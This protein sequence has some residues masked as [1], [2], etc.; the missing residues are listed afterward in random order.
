MN[1]T[2]D[3][4]PTV[5][6]DAP[7]IVLL[8]RKGGGRSLPRE[9]VAEGISGD[10]FVWVHAPAVDAAAGILRSLGGVPEGLAE[11][12]SRPPEL[13][14]LLAVGD[15]FS[16][17]LRGVE[18]PSGPPD[19]RLGSLRVWLDA[20]RFVSVG[21]QVPPSIREIV[22]DLEAGAGPTGP[23]DL[24]GRVVLRLIRDLGAVLDADS[25]ALDM[26][27]SRILT[28]QTD[29]LDQELNQVRLRLLRLH[30]HL[31]PQRTLVH[32]LLQEH[33][34]HQLA[35]GDGLST[36]KEASDRMEDRLERLDGLRE[37][38]GA[39]QDALTDMRSQRMNDALYLLSLYTALFLPMGVLTG[40]LG[41]NV[42]GVP[43]EKTVWAFWLVCGILVV[44]GILSYLVFRR[45]G[46][47]QSVRRDQAASGGDSGTG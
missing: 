26:L 46:L 10:A 47:M 44:L 24:L 42:A 29:H 17:T 38:C 22:G 45:M 16:M 8:D 19:V 28:R 43:G 20:R 11:V 6:P 27:E 31:S 34:R 13:P 40:L 18:S 33:G 35:T 25:A 5:A 1:E 39:L 30:R 3:A 36:L 41:I 14:R 32:E 12:F 15:G 4:K 23:A 37:H 21:A 7:W 9:S 2:R